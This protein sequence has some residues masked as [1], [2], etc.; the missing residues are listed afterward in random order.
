MKFN[1]GIDVEPQM[2]KVNA[3]LKTN[4]V[5]EMEELLKEFKDVFSWT[6]KD[7]KGIPPKLAQHRIELDITVLPA[8]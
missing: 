5:L 6:Y 2:M 7:L 8:H 3:Q 4:K 1:L